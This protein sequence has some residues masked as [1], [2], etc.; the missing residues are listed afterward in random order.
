MDRSTEFVF[1]VPWVMS[2]FHQDWRLGASTEAEAVAGRFVEE[3]DAV[4]PVRRDALLLHGGL[5]HD[6]I[7]VLREACADIERLLDA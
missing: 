7:T 6:R 4:L 3:P 5:P 1:G 2:F